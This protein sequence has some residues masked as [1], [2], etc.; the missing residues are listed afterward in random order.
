MTNIDK[1]TNK[2]LLRDYFNKWKKIYDFDKHQNDV[3]YKKYLLL[4]KIFENRYNIEYISLLQ[5]LLRW[6]NKMLEIRAKEMHK[7]YRKKVIKILLTKNDKE[8]LQRYFTRWK[9]S[10][11]RR[12]PIMP[13]IVAKRFLKKVLC[14]KAYKEFVKKMTE[15]NPRILK[16]KGKALIKL[17]K[18]IKDKR[19]RDFLN[20]L[21]KAIQAKYLGKIVPK[22]N[23]KIKEYY[24]KKY[25][26]RWVENT[27]KDAQRKKELIA[28]WLQRKFHE[29]QLK[30]DKKLKNL[31][32]K[33]ITKKIS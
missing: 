31:L 10:G 28:K 19:I 4:S 23:D 15:R 5:Y 32:T 3:E 30:N 21:L 17:I 25:W 29:Q 33:F 1:K 27:L 24:L 26:D 9:Y 22:V 2:E 6:K 16:E 12:L 8:E 18:N 20:K 11:Y 14:R 7:P 13:Y